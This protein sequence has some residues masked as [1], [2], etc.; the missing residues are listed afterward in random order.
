MFERKIANNVVKEV[1]G[2]ESINGTLSN[3]N[4]KRNIGKDD[5]TVYAV[6]NLVINGWPSILFNLSSS[7]A[8]SS[9]VLNLVINGWPSIHKLGFSQENREAE[10]LNLVINGWPSIQYLYYIIPL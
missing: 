1:F 8:K 10:V 6:L 5:G 9:E 3:K 4:S 7:L 2:Y